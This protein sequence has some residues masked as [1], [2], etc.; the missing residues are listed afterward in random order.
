MCPLTVED[1]TL[2]VRY[3]SE[4]IA[5]IKACLAALWDDSIVF[6]ELGVGYGVADVVA[7]RPSAVGVRQRLR[8]RQ[9]ATLPR[10]GEVQVVLALRQVEEATFDLL[11][12]LTGISAKR[13]RYDVLR[14]LL[15]ENY[16][17][18]IAD[19]TFQL[20]GD[21][22]P[23]A[24]EIWA[25]EA[26]IE[27]WFKGLCQAKRYQHFAH[28]TYLAIAAPHRRRV[29][30]EILREQNVGLI[31][32]SQDRAEIVF[33]PRRHWP[34]S[35]ELFLMTNERIWQQIQATA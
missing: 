17:E 6:E 2:L 28:K 33:H 16:V 20:L 3:E 13:L 8:L 32:V 11:V 10:R 29:R 24:Q 14:F 23:V 27:N 5:P 9:T 7:A 30:D 31:T 21:Y 19:D 18:K 35:E 25:V 1:R 12:E 15:A 4:M 26:K 34:R 22:R